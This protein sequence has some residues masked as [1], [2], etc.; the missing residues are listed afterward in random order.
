VPNSLSTISFL[1][2]TPNAVEGFFLAKK[3]VVPT[4]LAARQVGAGASHF[5]IQYSLFIIETSKNNI[6][7]RVTDDELFLN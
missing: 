5:N 3:D 1:L 4:R 2:V 6:E 7:Q